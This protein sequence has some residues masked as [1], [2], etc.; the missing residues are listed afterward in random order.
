[1]PSEGGLLIESFGTSRLRS[2]EPPLGK[3]SAIR[4][5]ELPLELFERIEDF[6]KRPPWQA[7]MGRAFVFGSAIVLA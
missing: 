3:T 6:P 1:M 2:L 4:A 7:K 5:L